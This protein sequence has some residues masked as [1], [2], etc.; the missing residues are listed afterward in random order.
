MARAVVPGLLGNAALMLIHPTVPVMDMINFSSGDVHKCL[1]ELCA[2]G[3][4]VT[5][6]LNSGSWDSGVLGFFDRHV[7]VYERWDL[8]RSEPSG[9]F[10][11]VAMKDLSRIIVW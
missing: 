8:S 3:Y 10:S 5:V 9:S 11:S 2:E 1:T 6:E 4:V 7:L